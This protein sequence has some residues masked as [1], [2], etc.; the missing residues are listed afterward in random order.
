MSGKFEYYEGKDGWRW[1]LV[2]GNG[3]PI[4]AGEAYSSKQAVLDGIDR[5]IR[6]SSDMHDHSV[7]EASLPVYHNHHG[8]T[9]I[10]EVDG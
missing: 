8:G 10:V 1:R 5:V 9:T 3:E 7:C 2:A 6:Y 4:A